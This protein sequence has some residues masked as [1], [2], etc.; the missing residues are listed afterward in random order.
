MAERIRAVDRIEEEHEA[1]QRSIDS[2]RGIAFG[3]QV[4][5]IGFGIGWR[6]FG[7]FEARMLLLHPGG[8]ATGVLGI[9]RNG[10]GR[11]IWAKEGSVAPARW[12]SHST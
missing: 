10:S 4:I 12:Q 9:Q 8:K 6:D 3:K 1:D 2:R 7:G 5:P 11:E